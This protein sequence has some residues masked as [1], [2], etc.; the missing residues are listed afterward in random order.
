MDLNGGSEDKKEEGEVD[1]STSE[2]VSDEVSVWM[3]GQDKKGSFEAPIEKKDKSDLNLSPSYFLASISNNETQEL[4]AFDAQ[5]EN[6]SMS[7]SSNQNFSDLD[8]CID[9]SCRTETFSVANL[10]RG[11]QP[12]WQKTEDLRPVACIRFNA[13]LGKAKPVTIKTL[14]DSS[15]SDTTVNKKFAK[16]IKSKGHSRFQ[17]GVDCTCRRHED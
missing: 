1:L 16:N 4:F 2:D 10:I 12:K 8:D 6:D 13:S 17:H 7:I 15:A 3:A 5:E 11:R 14:P 9:Q